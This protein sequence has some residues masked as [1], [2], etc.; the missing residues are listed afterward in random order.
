MPNDLV[1]LA[2]PSV[3]ADCT[4]QHRIVISICTSLMLHAGILTLQQGGAFWAKSLQGW[5]PALRMSS[6]PAPINVTLAP[7]SLQSAT[8]SPPE[9]ALQPTPAILPPK[10]TSSSITETG[11]NDN[12]TASQPKGLEEQAKLS[13]GLPLSN[14]FEMDDVSI[15]ATVADE[16]DQD[17]PELDRIS[18]QGKATLVFYINEF[19]KVDKLEFLASNLG[20][21]FEDVLA[22]R[23][24]KTVFLPA[25][26]DG[27]AVKSRLRIEITIR[28]LLRR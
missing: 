17:P 24:S 21:Q 12:G 7:Y 16:V 15:R 25:Q 3:T 8:R 9:S 5:S 22:Q 26:I 2:D 27:V 10:N 4:A 13:P 19:G 11:H 6:S 18:G 23:Y 28:P 14:Y 20:A 1:R